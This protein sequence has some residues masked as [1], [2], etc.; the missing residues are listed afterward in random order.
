[1]R[2]RAADGRESPTTPGGWG[3]KA[4]KCGLAARDALVK[5]IANHAVRCEEGR[6]GVEESPVKNAVHANGL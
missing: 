3:R 6:T 5:Q 2:E 4:W 1:L